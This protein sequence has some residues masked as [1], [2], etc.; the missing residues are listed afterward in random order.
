MSE[1]ERSDSVKKQILEPVRDA[2]ISFFKEDKRDLTV[3]ELDIL[4]NIFSQKMEKMWGGVE[5]S[6]EYKFSAKD[7]FEHPLEVQYLLLC[8]P[9]VLKKV[10]QEPEREMEF[11]DF[12]DENIPDVES[13]EDFYEFLRNNDLEF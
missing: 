5:I 12:L 11:W 10:V 9:I 7:I 1:K 8:Y 13:L 4:E 6:E 2:V 3:A